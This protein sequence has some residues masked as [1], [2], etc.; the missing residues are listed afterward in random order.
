VQGVGPLSGSRA[1]LVRNNRAGA[2][3]AVFAECTNIGA[4]CTEAFGDDNKIGALPQ[5]PKVEL[6]GNSASAYGNNVATKATTMLYHE[7]A[8]SSITVPIQK[9]HV[10]R[11]QPAFPQSPKD[12]ML[13]RASAIS[14]LL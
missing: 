10:L 4:S 14:R 11:Y 13:R 2:G 5:L 8:N 1:I 6:A 9:V 3:G 12:S 7:G